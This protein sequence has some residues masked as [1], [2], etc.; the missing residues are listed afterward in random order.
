VSR[1]DFWQ[2]W[3][4]DCLIW[5]LWTRLRLGGRIRV[6]MSSRPPI[7]RFYWLADGQEWAYLPRFPKRSG[8][9]ALIYRGTV[10]RLA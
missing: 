8:W 10:R 2:P 3:I 9:N 5:V 6:R 4:A 1:K 7:P